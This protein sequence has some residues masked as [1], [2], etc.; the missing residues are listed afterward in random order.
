MLL[1]GRG[2]LRAEDLAPL[3]SAPAATKG[4]T[5]PPGVPTRSL[6]P[7]EARR[8]VALELAASPSGVATGEFARVV[9]VG[10]SL[11]R[12]ELGALV[13]AGDLRRTGRGRAVRYVR[14]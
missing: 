10:L 9:D 14:P 6:R 12:R 13:A 11:A 5:E 7:A 3:E 8:R 1:R 4:D 2:W